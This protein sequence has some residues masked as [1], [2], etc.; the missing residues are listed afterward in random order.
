MCFLMENSEDSFIFLPIGWADFS[1]ETPQD[2]D[3]PD[4]WRR[5]Q[6]SHSRS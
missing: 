6:R 2:I 1:G 4:E 3:D 5:T